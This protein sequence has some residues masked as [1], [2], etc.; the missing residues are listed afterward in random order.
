MNHF[1]AV[2]KLNSADFLRWKSFYLG[3]IDVRFGPRRA[4][5]GAGQPVAEVEKLD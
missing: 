2:D 5:I 3:K 4:A 1:Y